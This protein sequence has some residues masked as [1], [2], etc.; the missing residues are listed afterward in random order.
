MVWDGVFSATKTTL[1]SSGSSLAN[2]TIVEANT[3]V[4]D[5][6]SDLDTVAVLE[7][8]GD[9]TTAPDDNNPTLDFYYQFSADGTNYSS[10]PLTGGANQSQ[11]F[12][13]SVDVRKVGSGT[14]QDLISVP[15]PIYPGKYKIFVDNQTGQSLDSTWSLDIYAASI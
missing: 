8:S 10:A 11:T 14:V 13:T 7:F 12:L 6:T 5:N 9:W 15:F 3:N 2:D 4:F 1:M